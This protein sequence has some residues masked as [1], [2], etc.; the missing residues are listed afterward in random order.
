MRKSRA[1]IGV[2]ALGVLVMAAGSLAFQPG[3]APKGDPKSPAPAHQPGEG[4]HRGGSVESAMKQMN[5]ARKQLAAQVADAAKADENIRLVNDMQRAC[6]T[7][8]GLG[9]PQS[10]VDKAKDAAAKSAAA[11]TFRTHLIAAM[12]TLLE[13]EEALIAA[14]PG[15][16]KA[17]LDVLETMIEK[18][19]KALGVE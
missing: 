1:M 11:T 17:K 19:H 4:G 12:R 6:A 5:R 9:V 15:E 3:T 7:A 18:G 14:N 13:I 16:A 2:A 8:K 10:I